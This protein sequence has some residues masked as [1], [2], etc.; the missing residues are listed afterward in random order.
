[1]KHNPLELFSNLLEHPKKNVRRETCW[2]ISNIVAT[3]TETADMVLKNEKLFKLILKL[4]ESD[5][6]EVNFIKT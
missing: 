2:I 4:V 1:M 6:I 5:C 3:N